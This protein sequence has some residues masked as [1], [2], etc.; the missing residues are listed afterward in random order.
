MRSDSTHFKTHFYG[1]HVPLEASPFYCELCSFRSESQGPI[2]SHLQGYKPHLKKE[3]EMMNAG[4]RP[5]GEESLKQSINHVTIKEGRDYKRYDVKQSNVI[6]EAK[7]GK[8]TPRKETEEVPPYIPQPV[9]VGLPP[10]I[11]P[12]YTPTSTATLDLQWFQ[13]NLL[14]SPTEAQFQSPPPVFAS[15]I[16]NTPTP[17]LNTPDRSHLTPLILKSTITAALPLNNTDSMIYASPPP[18]PPPPHIDM[19]SVSPVL[20]ITKIQNNSPATTPQKT[21]EQSL[22]QPVSFD[23]T[24]PA[25]PDATIHTSLTPPPPPPHIE[26]PC[27]SPI[28]EITKIKNNSPTTTLQNEPDKSHTRRVSFD[29]TLPVQRPMIDTA[30]K[31]PTSSTPPPPHIEIPSEP[32]LKAAKTTKKRKVESE[33]PREENFEPDYNDENE[34]ETQ[35]SQPPP[36]H[37]KSKNDASKLIAS[38]EKLQ[39]TAENMVDEMRKC[40]KSMDAHAAVFQLMFKR[41]HEAEIAKTITKT[42]TSLPPERKDE[43]KQ[44]RSHRSPRHHHHQRRH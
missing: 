32:V 8:K 34:L 15:S 29:N 36:P 31:I 7:Y 19:A 6:W 13:D 43:R 11:H 10:V 37:K 23:N 20:K 12:I 4:L 27:E 28:P 17:P 35:E 14:S 24:L 44:E 1:K 9:R 3:K 21:P 26:M 18:P 25:Q 42:Q 38:I 5:L 16:M 2:E 30:V 22:I 41:Y 40:R 39:Q 33:E